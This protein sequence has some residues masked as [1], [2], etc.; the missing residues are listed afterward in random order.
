CFEENFEDYL[1]FIKEVSPK[2]VIPYHYT[3]EK[4][5]N[6]KNLVQFLN[7][8]DINAQFLNIGDFIEI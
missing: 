3:T 6:S 7:K 5:E 8:N 1:K 2:K 4:E